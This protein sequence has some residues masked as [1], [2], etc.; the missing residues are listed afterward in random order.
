VD[1]HLGSHRVERPVVLLMTSTEGATVHTGVTVEVGRGGCS[2]QLDE[3]IDP[4]RWS[5]AS[6]VLL[7]QLA[8]R[9]VVALAGAPT[10]EDARRRTI[11]LTL[12]P[13]TR[14]EGG[15]VEWVRELGESGAS[16]PRR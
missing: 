13:T 8:H 10:L 14:D 11:W 3:V 5:G 1:E 12:V 7:V 2:L 15:W 9:E 6:G 16:T 4:T